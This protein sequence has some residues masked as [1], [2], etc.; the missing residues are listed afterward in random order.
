[1]PLN[2]KQF[3]GDIVHSTYRPIDN[4]SAANPK[5]VLKEL[6]ELLEAYGPIWY[7]EEHHKRALAALGDNF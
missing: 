7:T 6:F 5:L 2:L 4:F 3:T 1:M